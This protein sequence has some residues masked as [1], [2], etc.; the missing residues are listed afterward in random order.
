VLDSLLAAAYDREKRFTVYRRG[1]ATDVEARFASHD[2]E[3]VHRDL[4]P[5]GPEPFLVIED[6]GEF[7]GALSLADLAALL[8]PP[9][10]RPGERDDVS[11][12]YRVLFDVL[13]G[14]VFTAMDRRQ[15]LAV[16]REIEDRAFR[17]GAGRLHAGFQTLSTFESQTDVYRRLAAET[18]LDVHVHG[19]ADWTPPAIPGVTYHALAADSLDQYWVLAFDGGPD[20]YRACGLVAQERADG[21]RGFWTDDPGTVGDILAALGAD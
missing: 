8:D 10:V 16:S 1:E 15:L 6:G 14:T 19:A 4:P 3:V 20:E 2:V 5:G 9:I 11:A 12:G 21:Y 7:A 18:D 13:D 17:T